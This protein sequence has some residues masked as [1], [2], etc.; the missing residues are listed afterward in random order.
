MDHLHEECYIKLEEVNRIIAAAADDINKAPKGVLH[1]SGKGNSVQYYKKEEKGTSR[2][3]IRKSDIITAKQL[4]QKAYANK[5]VNL[6]RFTFSS[7]VEKA[8]QKYF[9]TANTINMR[10]IEPTIWIINCFMFALYNAL[11]NL[12]EVILIKIN[13]I[14]NQNTVV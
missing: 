4:A 10:K 9:C 13:I 1:V 12:N 7:S 14:V 11:E 2:Q 3:Y 8:P 6:S 5:V